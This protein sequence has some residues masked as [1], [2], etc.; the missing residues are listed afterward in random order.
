MQEV[1]VDSSILLLFGH[2]QLNEIE[3]RLLSWMKPFRHLQELFTSSEKGPQSM[4]NFDDSEQSKQ[5][6]SHWEHVVLF[7]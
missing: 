2:L 6:K 3:G 1:F 4:Q 5:L 7:K